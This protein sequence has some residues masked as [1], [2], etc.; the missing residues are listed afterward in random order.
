MR[1]LVSEGA[2][3]PSGRQVKC[4]HCGHQWFQEGEEGLDE[5]LFDSPVSND[6]VPDVEMIDGPELPEYQMT[7]E[8]ASE[9][10]LEQRLSGF[11]SILQKEIDAAEALTK[12]KVEEIPAGVRPTDQDE[13]VIPPAKTKK[14]IRIPKADA[15]TGGFLA[16]GA[17]FL[18]MLC[19][20]LVLQPQVSRIWPASNLFY[21]F[22]GMKAAAPGAG[23]T[24]NN[25]Q[26]K[27]E[28]GHVYMM[29]D[30]TNPGE[31]TKSVPTVLATFI[32]KND[33]VVGTVLIAPPSK[34]VEPGDKASFDVTYD[35]APETAE[36]VTFAFTYMKAR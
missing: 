20:L 2:V 12:P 29:G 28:D 36:A 24:L 8:E 18:G 7:E 31:E 19:L 32:D 22:F 3:G 9:A 6:S 35:A 13:V 17:V 11:Q 23:L 33:N 25:L 10:L 21:S 15:R 14:A 26:A 4:A 16:A 5:A 30:I 1:Y 27:F 34:I